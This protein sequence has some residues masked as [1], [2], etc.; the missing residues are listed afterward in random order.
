MIVDVAELKEFASIFWVVAASLKRGK[1]FKENDLEICIKW[2]ARVAN[3]VADLTKLSGKDRRRSW[4]RKGWRA[5]GRHH[6]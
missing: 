4:R 1:L 2:A 3:V 5:A 6:G